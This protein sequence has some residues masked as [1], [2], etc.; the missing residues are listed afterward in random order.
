MPLDRSNITSRKSNE[1][2]SPFSSSSPSNAKD[3]KSSPSF[4]DSDFADVQNKITKKI[5][6]KTPQ[7]QG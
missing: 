4:T 6:K 5:S 3:I 1:D 2:D 7:K